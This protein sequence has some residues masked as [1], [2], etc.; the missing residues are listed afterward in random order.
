[1][2]SSRSYVRFVTAV[3]SYYMGNTLFLFTLLGVFTN[4]TQVVYESDYSVRLVEKLRLNI[5]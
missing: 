2:M 1:M 3:E 4:E 5:F